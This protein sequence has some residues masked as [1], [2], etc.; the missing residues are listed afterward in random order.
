[1]HKLIFGPVPSSL[2][3]SASESESVGM[4]MAVYMGTVSASEGVMGI[5]IWKDK[6]MRSGRGMKL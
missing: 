1:M 5:A 4:E 6:S 2:S 3:S